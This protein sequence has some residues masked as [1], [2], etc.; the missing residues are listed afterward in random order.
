RLSLRRYIFNSISPSSAR[1]Y[2]RHACPLY[3]VVFMHLHD[4]GESPPELAGPSRNDP[5][6]IIHFHAL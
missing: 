3:V 1:S 2:P 4:T 5:F 6:A